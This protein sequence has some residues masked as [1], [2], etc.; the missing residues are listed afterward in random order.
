MAGQSE[1]YQQALAD[2]G[3]TVEWIPLDQLTK[4]YGAAHCMTQVMRRQAYAGTPITAIAPGRFVAGTAAVAPLYNLQGQ[5]AA[6]QPAKGI[7]VA[8]GNKVVVK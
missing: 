8:K 5:R 7:Y 3:V 6:E 4:G 1:A 2:E